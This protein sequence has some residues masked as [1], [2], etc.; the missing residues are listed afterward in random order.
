MKKNSTWVNSTFMVEW[1][2]VCR[3]LREIMT[4]DILL[5]PIE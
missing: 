5:V 3:L 4:H 2:Y 1:D